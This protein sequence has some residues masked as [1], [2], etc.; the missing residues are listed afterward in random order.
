MLTGYKDE[1][2]QETSIVIS[3]LQEKYDSYK[4]GEKTEDEAKEEAKEVI[5]NMRYGENDSGYFWIDDLDYNL[6]M[7]PIL[8]DQEGSNRKNLEDKN[9][10]LIVQE[11]VKA[12]KSK[13][14]S[15]Y[16]EFYFTKDD[17]VTVAPKLAYSELFKPWGWIVSTGNYTDTLD[18]NI[19]LVQ[20]NVEKQG[21]KLMIFIT[22]TGVVMLSVVVFIAIKIG[23]KICNPLKEIQDMSDRMKE[24][25]LRVPAKVMTSDELGA[26]ATSLNIA[27]KQVGILV[28]GI[29]E[30]TD[31]LKETV[32]QCV[33]NFDNMKKSISNVTQAVEE[34]AQN[35][36]S[37]A[38]ETSLA[39][40]K[41]VN[42]ADEIKNVYIIVD[43]LGKESKV[44]ED[45]S[46]KSMLALKKLI[47]VNN[48]TRTN[49][50][51]MK[52][53]TDDTNLSVEKINNSA[54]LISEIAEQTNL[55]AL[56]ASI[57][58]ARAGEAG[59]GF[60]VVAEEIGK[61]AAQSSSAAQE[62]NNV[63]EELNANSNK[64]VNMMNA[65]NKN[66]YE[67]ITTLNDTKD[68]FDL[69]K[70]SSNECMKHIDE[71][72][73]FIKHMDNEREVLTSNIDK[74]SSLSMDNASSTEETSATALDLESIVGHSEE[75]MKELS[76]KVKSLSDSIDIFKI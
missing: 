25:N 22:L 4:S 49:I 27:Q 70:D 20:S 32:K 55:L 35:S 12:A 2:S 31:T 73:E 48:I 52:E 38:Q 42:I 71:V 59:K 17:G 53:Q 3:I 8:T 28:A 65:M 18:K 33:D 34:I 56:N 41:I 39:D 54:T 46:D 51:D 64:S 11:I 68:M 47:D 23:D 21:N 13:N 14:G 44:M 19:S 45:C 24:G 30:T 50:A 63:I 36:T 5:R 29:N 75:K 58:A 66:S 26:T 7:H 57:E 43:K 15:G 61:L 72:V 76:E 69:L 37:Q 40:E 9:G 6:I 16:N 60:A 67:E 62:I 10:V 1:I 74:L